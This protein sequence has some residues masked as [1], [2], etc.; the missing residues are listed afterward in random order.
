M[1]LHA[2]I[3]NTYLVPQYTISTKAKATNSLTKPHD[4]LFPCFLQ[5]EKLTFELPA[6]LILLFFL[7]KLVSNIYLRFIF[8]QPISP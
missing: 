3:K 7:K 2:F 4:E 6:R 5:T 1:T 8:A